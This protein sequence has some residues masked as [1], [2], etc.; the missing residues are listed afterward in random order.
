MNARAFLKSPEHILAL[1]KEAVSASPVLQEHLLILKKGDVL[2]GQNEVL[3]NLYLLIGSKV[4]LSRTLPDGTEISRMLLKPGNFVGLISFTTNEPTLTTAQVVEDGEALIL[5]PEEFEYYLS[6]TAELMPLFRQLV[7]HN[8]VE[9]YKL[10]VRLHTKTVQLKNKLKKEKAE[11]EHAYEELE[12]SHQRLVHQEKMAALGKMTAG[13]AHE[14][15]N[16]ASALIRASENLISLYS[17]FGKTDTNYRF[18]QF[19][20]ESTPLDSSVLRQKMTQLAQEFPQVKDRSTLRKLAAMPDKALDI[21]RENGRPENLEEVVSH[22]E[23]GKLVH[24]ISLASH[25]IANL[26]KSLKNYSRSGSPDEEYTDVRKG[27]MDSVQMLSTRLKFINLKLDLQDV[28]KTCLYASS[29]NQVWTNIIINA[30]DAL[31]GKGEILI[32]AKMQNGHILVEISDN[33]PGIPKEIL[34]HIFEIN[35]TTKNQGA[36]F[37]LGL[38][39]AISRDIVE[40][41]GGVIS[42][43]NKDG[44]GAVFSVLLPVR[45]DC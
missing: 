7:L 30:C 37:G 26:V 13:F 20:L 31:G 21:F 18:F 24:N 39:L 27:L 38:G 42:A 22:F 12:R 25:R 23:A 41:A 19:G 14:V 1:I 5:T 44:G 15:N 8:M 40:Q 43:A 16:P 35:F 45:D 4:E 3:K 2:F 28:P 11:V 36:A 10:N 32:S 29:M 9:R 6:E 34:P 33:G 17:L